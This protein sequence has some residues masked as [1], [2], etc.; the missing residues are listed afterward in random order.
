MGHVELAGGAGQQQLSGKLDGLE[1]DD[2]SP[3]GL[4]SSLECYLQLLIRVVILPQLRVAIPKLVFDILDLATITL[5]ATPAPGVIPNNPAIEDD[6]LKAFI[7]F[8]VAP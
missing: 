8:A 4:E 3:D 7:D 2:I 5:S 6:Q 1:I